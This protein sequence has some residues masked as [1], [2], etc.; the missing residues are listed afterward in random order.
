MMGNPLYLI[1]LCTIAK[2]NLF[3]EEPSNGTQISI[4]REN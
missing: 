3:G 4:N 2:I 1:M